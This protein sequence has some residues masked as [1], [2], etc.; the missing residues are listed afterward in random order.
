[1]LLALW[2]A[3]G[4]KGEG[5]RPTTVVSVADSADQ[6]LQGFRHFVT[7][8][9]V[10]DGEIEADT[11][12]F[13]D[14]TQTTLLRRMRVVFFDSAGGQRAVITA[15]HGRYLWQKGSM[16]AEGGVVLTTAD[17]KTLKSEKLN[18]DAEKQELSTD[19][20]FVFDDSQS[21]VEGQGFTSDMQFANIRAAKPTGRAREGVLLPGQ[22]E[23]PDSAGDR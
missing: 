5:V 18:Y 7:R 21:H 9:G 2:L 13:Y 23:E 12:F 16:L 15:A 10:R 1:M 17:G 19:V 4:C 22:S 14:D 3:A 20:P 6:V 11:A 8:D